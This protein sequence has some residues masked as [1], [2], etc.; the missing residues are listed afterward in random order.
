MFFAPEPRFS[1][2]P[3]LHKPLRYLYVSPLDKI[4]NLMP[5]VFC[6]QKKNEFIFWNWKKIGIVPI[7]LRLNK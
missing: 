4:K 3:K 6:F 2:A 1:K 5:E 7:I